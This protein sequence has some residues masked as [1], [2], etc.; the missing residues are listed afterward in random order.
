MTQIVVKKKSIN[1]GLKGHYNINSSQQ[2]IFIDEDLNKET[3]ELYKKA[4][5]FVKSGFQIHRCKNGKIYIKKND[6]DHPVRVKS[7]NDVLTKKGPSSLT[8]TPHFIPK[9]AS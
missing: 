6:A 7:K 5:N 4:R 9:D 3:S 2:K 1:F 8:Q